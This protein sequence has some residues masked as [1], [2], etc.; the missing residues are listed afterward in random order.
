M[1]ERNT[2]DRSGGIGERIRNARKLSGLSQKELAQLSGVSLSWIRKL[3]QGEYNETRIETLRQLAAALGTPTTALMGPRPD[4]GADDTQDM[5]TPTREALLSPQPAAAPE[6]GSQR[7]LASAITAAV[8]LYHDNRYETL[9]QVLPALI[10]EARDAAPLLR[11]QAY[12][13]AGSIMT[14]TRQR[15][16]ARIALDQSVADAASTGEMLEAGTAVITQCWL[17][18]T[19]GRFEE[20]RH[21]A[22][23]WSD[24][25]EPRFSAATNRELSVWGWL[26][27]RGSAAAVRDNRPDEA[28]DMMRLAEAAA[29]AAGGERGS[30]KMYWTTFG[31]ST[32]RMKSAENAVVGG[33]PDVALKIARRVPSGLRPTS[34]NRN[35]HLLDVAEA[36]RQMKNYDESF[37]VLRQ[38]RGEAP[39]WLAEQPMARTVLGRLVRRRRTPP[40]EMREMAGAIRLEL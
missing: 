30:Y 10:G 40:P 2:E 14:Q 20:V 32:V 18:L 16:A 19:Q 7:G 6:P 5:W 29:V 26:L 3:E 34:D 21:L 9:A 38:L 1:T 15:E 36:H 27:L 39:A 22:S 11:S 24:R 28:D 8:K 35:R 4:T 17:M 37:D 31:V 33:R 23:D 12:Q 25:I 13:L